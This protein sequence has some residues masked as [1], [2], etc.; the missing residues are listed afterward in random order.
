MALMRCVRPVAILALAEPF[1]MRSNVQLTPKRSGLGR[2]AGAVAAGVDVEVADHAADRE[3]A[4]RLRIGVDEFAP[5]RRVLRVEPAGG[6]G[7][8]DAVDV[9]LR[10]VDAADEGAL[11]GAEG[12]VG[13]GAEVGVD[14]DCAAALRDEAEVAEPLLLFG[15][16]EGIVRGVAHAFGALADGAGAAAGVAG[17]DGDAEGFGDAIDQDAAAER[18]LEAAGGGV[19]VAFGGGVAG[20]VGEDPEAAA[21]G[22]WLG[23][24]QVAGEDGVVG[25]AGGVERGEG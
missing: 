2:G 13:V 18:A 8:D 4:G 6:V 25:E 19:D 15:D 11:E 14:G 23:G 7:A 24:E 12:G 22:K 16:E 3:R 5:G 17:C 9:G 20:R 10:G 1:S 21:G